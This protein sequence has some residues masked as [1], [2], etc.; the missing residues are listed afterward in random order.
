M[1]F[2]LHDLAFETTRR[3]N[4]HCAHCM[5][6]TSQNID[7][8]SEVI[9]AFFDNNEFERIDH[10]CF[11]GGEPTL[12]PAIIIYTID[13]IIRENIDVRD[14]AM[15]TNGQ[16]F[17]PELVEAFHR[18]NEYRNSCIIKSI[19]REDGIISELGR[20]IV[21]SNMDNHVRITFSTD[22][23]HEDINSEVERRYMESGKGLKITKFAVGD[24]DI[25]KTGF[26]TFGQS[27]EYQLPSLRYTKEP[28]AYF[29]LDNI[30]MTSNGYLTSEGNGQYVDMDHMNMGHV[31]DT[32]I[33]EALVN[34]GQAIF[35]TPPITSSHPKIKKI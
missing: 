27:F 25:Y 32:S 14:I 1:K 22:R 5:R 11:S 30:Y 19:A 31:S 28:D 33:E 12:N 13:K 6:G 4:L 9:D 35:G 24:D 2:I 7:L 20:C 17:V 21:D 29:I 8:T 34:Y 10:I 15:V 23:F 18:F 3:C 26:S 16:I